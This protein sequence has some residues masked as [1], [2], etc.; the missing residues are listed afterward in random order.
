MREDKTQ[1]TEQESTEESDNEILPKTTQRLKGQSTER[2]TNKSEI[3]LH[4][5]DDSF[6]EH[7]SELKL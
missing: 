1:L 3:N 2:I 6:S 5:S 7:L 4:I